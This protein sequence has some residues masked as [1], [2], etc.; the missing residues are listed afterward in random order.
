MVIAGVAAADARTANTSKGNGSG[1]GLETFEMQDRW[2]ADESCVRG[3]GSMA[4]LGTAGVAP[5]LRTGAICATG[6]K[7]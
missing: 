4:P 7:K 2:T 5:S 6:P 3:N 1:G